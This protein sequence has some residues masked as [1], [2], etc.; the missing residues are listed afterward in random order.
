MSLKTLPALPEIEKPVGIEFDPP[1]EVMARFRP[2]AA[3]DADRSLSVLGEIGEDFWGEGG[4]TA[5]RV[6]GILR[7]MGEGPVSVNLNSPGG[8]FFEG[9][10]IYN[11]LAQHKG[12]ITINVLGLAASA[13]SV[14]A[15]AGD[16]IRMGDASHLMIHNAWAIAIGNRHAMEEVRTALESFDG[17]MADLYVARSGAKREEI[18]AMMDAETFIAAARAV[19]L[20]LADEVAALPAPT[21]EAKAS[22]ASARK[23]I[24]VHLAKA[25]VPRTERR[26]LFGEMEAGTPGAAGTATPGAGDP[27]WLATAQATI[28]NLTR[29]APNG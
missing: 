19:D 27:D 20:G 15:M 12:K 21:T 14:I 3:A 4:W 22:F 10:A 7:R 13:A 17:A 28:S 9:V 2:V 11:L 29:S 26:R 24:D 23:T 16:E 25:G 1:A 5:E 18:Q 6:D 8:D